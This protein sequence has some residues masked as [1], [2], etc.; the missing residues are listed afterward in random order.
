[1]TAKSSERTRR[2]RPAGVREEARCGGSDLDRPSRTRPLVRRDPQRSIH[3]LRRLDNFALARR[4]PF[5]SRL[6]LSDWNLV[7]GGNA[8]RRFLPSGCRG[9]AKGA[10]PGVRSPDSR[11]QKARASSTFLFGS[12]A[13]GQVGPVA[14]GLELNTKE[15]V[16]GPVVKTD[17]KVPPRLRLMLAS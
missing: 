12:G 16:A 10:P 4:E 17:A 9:S 1:M 5:Y 11:R 2:P 6:G 13:P 15:L 8:S 3:N 7:P 14:D